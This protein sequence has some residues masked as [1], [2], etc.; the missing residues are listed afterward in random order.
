MIIVTGA[1]GGIGISLLN[2]LKNVNQPCLAITTSEVPKD[3]N[4]LIEYVRVSKSGEDQALYKEYLNIFKKYGHQTV[5]LALLHGVVSYAGGEDDFLQTFRENIEVNLVLTNVIIRAF[6]ASRQSNRKNTPC[7]VVLVGTASA[8]RGGRI[9]SNPGYAV[10][11]YALQNLV[12]AYGKC[13]AD[14]LCRFNCVAL[15]FIDSGLHGKNNSMFSYSERVSSIPMGRAGSVAEAS[16]VIR[17]LFSGD[18]EFINGQTL[19]VDGGDF[20]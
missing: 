12:K 15:G 1:Q 20:I 3:T 10:A 8:N 13:Y 5:G 14:T 6:L 11:K 7:S 9:D 16:S 18:S 19:S 4:D 2:D 17:F